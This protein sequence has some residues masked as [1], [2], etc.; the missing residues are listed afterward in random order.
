MFFLYNSFIDIEIGKVILHFLSEVSK[1]DFNDKVYE[2]KFIKI[3]SN[4][5]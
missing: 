4:S 1:T 5:Y 3:S 2:L